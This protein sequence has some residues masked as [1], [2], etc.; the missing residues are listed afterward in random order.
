MRIISQHLSDVFGGRIEYGG[1]P[2]LKYA[3]FFRNIG[4]I[5]FIGG[6]KGWLKKCQIDTREDEFSFAD[7]SEPLHPS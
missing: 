5:Y 4:T 6:C 3:V 2:Y 1:N 7:E